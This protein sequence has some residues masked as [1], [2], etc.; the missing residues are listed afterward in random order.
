MK[1]KLII[2]LLLIFISNSI[3][4]PVKE[5]A[6]TTELVSSKESIHPGE[7]IDIA[8]RIKPNEGWHTY[9]KSPGIV[10]VPTKIDWTLPEGLKVGEILWPQPQTVKMGPYD[11][12]GYHKEVFLVVPLTSSRSLE[13]GKKLFVKARVSWMCC[14]E[15]CQPGFAD[16]SLELPISKKSQPIKNT[17]WSKSIIKSR[18][19][20]P[21]VNES[22][23]TSA[24]RRGDDIELTLKKIKGKNPT[25][26]NNPYFFCEDGL[27]HSDKKQIIQIPSKESIVLKLHISEF[28]PKKP[29]HLKGI[30]FN[31]S[32]LPDNSGAPP[33]YI[34][35]PIAGY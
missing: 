14:S 25:T 5:G 2:G 17:E 28:G 16:L 29:T 21:S 1:L 6:L 27:I 13:F 23:E 11:A 34:N 8:L 9:W 33:I 10:G 7:T 32:G 4:K 22:W 26:P 35:A 3:S 30:F 18:S 20:F 31:K 15:V 19:T 12:Y 24:V